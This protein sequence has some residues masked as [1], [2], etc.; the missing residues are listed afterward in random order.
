[1]TKLGDQ[2]RNIARCYGVILLGAM[3]VEANMEFCIV[4]KK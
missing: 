3:R 1:M 2:A 4:F